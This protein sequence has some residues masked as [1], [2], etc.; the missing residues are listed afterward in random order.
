MIEHNWWASYFVPDPK[1]M[2]KPKIKVRIEDVFA[3]YHYVTLSELDIVIDNRKLRVPQ[4][5]AMGDALWLMLM[6]FNTSDGYLDRITKSTDRLLAG[7]RW[8]PIVTLQV[9]G[10]EWLKRL[11]LPG[12]QVRGMTYDVLCGPDEFYSRIILPLGVDFFFATL[13]P[14]M[15]LL[16]RQ[17]PKKKGRFKAVNE[18]DFNSC[19][20]M[21]EIRRKEKIKA[22]EIEKIRTDIK[23]K[24]S[25]KK[26]KKNKSKNKSL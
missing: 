7:L 22:D 2:L 3:T 9:K 17:Y 14:E 4:S 8:K 15:K 5:Y 1:K 18:H 19:P 11:F 13:V 20:L 10:E 25:K 6:Y 16:F 24:K 12:E 21:K 26:K 23:K